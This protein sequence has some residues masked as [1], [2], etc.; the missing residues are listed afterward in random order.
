MAKVQAS[1]EI[2]NLQGQAEIT[3]YIQLALQDIVA[4]VNGELEVT[5]NLKMNVVSVRF[6]EANKDVTIEHGLNK[7]P[8][9]Y[10]VVSRNS[11]GVQVFNGSGSNI[12]NNITI[13][14]RSGGVG[15][16]QIMFF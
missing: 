15:G 1:T 7:V 3:K 12:K 10:I 6:P 16:A 4:Q 9:G 14:L 11:T 8:T 13:R 2:T 5:N